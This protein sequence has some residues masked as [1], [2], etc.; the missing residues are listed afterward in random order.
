MGK[1]IRWWG[2]G[3]FVV[4]LGLMV[5]VWVLCVDRW[6]KGL[7]ED[8]GTKAVGAK[9]ELDAAEVT[10]VPA[11]LAL[12][13]LQVTDPKAPMT[14]AV[15]VARIR[16]GLDSLNLLGRKVI[17]EGMI[18]DGVRL[19]TP[20]T[21]SGAVVPT[22]P[23]RPE[24]EPSPRLTIPLPSV[25]VPDVKKILSEEDLETIRLID[26]LNDDMTREREAWEK[27]L[28]ELPGKEQVTG[29]RER[30]DAI[31]KARKGG[32]EGVLGGV[33]EAQALKQDIERE[34]DSLRQAR[35]EF[36][37]TLSLLRT[38]LKEVQTAPPRD[39]QRLQAKY[40]LSP[41]G[42]ANVSQ[43]LMGPEI[44]NWVR[45]GTEWYERLKPFLVRAR[46]AG[47]ER[48]TADVQKPLRGK[49]V[50]VVFQEVD[51][52]PDFLARTAKVSV[53]LE[54]GDL[55]GTIQNMTGDQPTLGKPMTFRFSGDRLTGVKSV[56][57]DGTM[58]HVVPE[59]PQT[60]LDLQARGY[61]LDHVSVSRDDRWP[62][63]LK[64]GLGDV[65]MQVELKGRDLIASGAADLKNLQL[66]AGQP[67][68]A[69][70]LTLALSSAVRDIS[71]LSI[72]AHVQ[73]TPE[74]YV[75]RVSSDLDRLVQ[76]AVGK[77]VSDLAA[78]FGA[79]LQAA[80]SKKIAEPMRQLQSRLSGLE[81]ISG[82]LTNRLGRHV[83]IL[84]SLAEK[85]L[86]A[87][88]LK[89]LPGGLKLPF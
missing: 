37:N 88:G 63:V 30:I 23:P 51:P 48:T 55:A 76:D 36:E 64:T 70:R 29:Y 7:I 42:L 6:I 80:L 26:S 1:W 77:I 74:Q 14:N 38:R 31:T 5:A 50:D 86:P 21:V 56:S 10:L 89:D 47:A 12:T 65:N 84:K 52:L 69:N 2:L 58:N 9:V 4:V 57:L 71:Q 35:T 32:L 45:T 61:I 24:I 62:L 11:G 53:S 75:V 73:G 41:Q 20:R 3:V 72:Q 81:S 59:D 78:T 66:S 22:P 40:N 8:V 18:V 60:H 67:D 49:G 79:D 33:G 85:H 44:G 43:A 39:I 13:R 54:I 15:E 16:M 25:E 17:I 46:A 82:E 19:G 68:D 28:K 83:D 87:K 34:I 27:R